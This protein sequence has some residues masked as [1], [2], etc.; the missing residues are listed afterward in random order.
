MFFHESID[1]GERLYSI[2]VLHR[3]LFHD[4]VGQC[5]DLFQWIHCFDVLASLIEQSRSGARDRQLRSEF[6]EFSV[7]VW[8]QR[9]H[10]IA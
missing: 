1:P 9:C 6:Q 3:Y 4:Q 8:F 2:R 10:G 5:R 7:V